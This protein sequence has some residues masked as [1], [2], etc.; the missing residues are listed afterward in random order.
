M[1]K[2]F[3]KQDNDNAQ[4]CKQ[5]TNEMN[6]QENMIATLKF[7]LDGMKSELAEFESQKQL[8]IEQLNREHEN[9]LDNRRL[10]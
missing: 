1:R 5:A 2:Q 10:S 8:E 3:L 9:K 6:V 4:K 7:K